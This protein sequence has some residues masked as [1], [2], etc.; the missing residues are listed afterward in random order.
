[1]KKRKLQLVLMAILAFVAGGLFQNCEPRH[2]LGVVESTSISTLYFEQT[3]YPLLATNCRRCHGI[4]REPLFAVDNPTESQDTIF[5]N[6]LVS[7]E[8]PGTSKLVNKIASGHN[9]L[10]QDLAE[11]LEAA[12][13]EWSRQLNILD[14]SSTLE[15]GTFSYLSSKILVP[16]CNSCHGPGGAKSSLDFTSYESLMNSDT[17]VSGQAL[18]STLYIATS[19]NPP[20]EIKRMPMNGAAL[21]ADELENLA[22]WINRGALKD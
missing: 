20:E 11:A 18:Q 1:M 9:Q 12:I 7:L 17:V 6:R 5:K 10:P 2:D 8:E 14:P 21:T 3:L 4:D 19:P 15:R 13:S 22:L 16:K